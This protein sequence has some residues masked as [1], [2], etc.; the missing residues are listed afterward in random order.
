MSGGW[1]VESVITTGANTDSIWLRRAVIRVSHRIL[2]NLL[3]LV[4]YQM[5]IWMYRRHDDFR[6]AAL[7]V[8]IA[9][10]Q[11]VTSASE[12]VG[13]YPPVLKVGTYPPVP[14]LR[15][16]CVLHWPKT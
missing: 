7:I 2:H 12:K 5:T 14:L 1:E 11:H 9:M 8:E 16:L 10:Q 3:C 6:S 13:D 15:R 4:T